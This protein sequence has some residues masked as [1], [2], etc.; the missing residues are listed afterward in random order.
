MTRRQ[1]YNVRCP[2]KDKEYN[3]DCEGYFMNNKNQ[4]YCNTCREKLTK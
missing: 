3:K 4:R 1:V 2:N